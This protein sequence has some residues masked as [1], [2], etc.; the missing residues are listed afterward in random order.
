M[1]F[2]TRLGDS[3]DNVPFLQV[4]TTP[5]SVVERIKRVLPG[6]I[7]ITWSVR[8]SN[9]DL[10]NDSD[11]EWQIQE[12]RIIGSIQRK[13]SLRRLRKRFGPFEKSDVHTMSAEEA[14]A[15]DLVATGVPL[16]DLENANY[17][18]FWQITGRKW[19]RNLT[20]FIER[21]LIRVQYDV[22]DD[23]LL[24]IA[25]IAQ[26]S[27]NQIASLV[28]SLLE[29]TPTS[30]AMIGDDGKSGIVL[31]RLPESSAYQITSTLPNEGYKH[32]MQIR[33]LRPTSYQSYSYNLYQRLL[34]EDGTWDD[35]VSAFL[36]QARS[37]RRELSES[38]A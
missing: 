21:E 31:S 5:L 3:R 29:N 30:L 24:S 8:N 34:R 27:P 33:C 1:R 32:D 16:D 28:E 36:S 35:D 25:T 23:R 38:N 17:T 13:G 22:R 19:K 10:F 18:D 6:A 7:Q 2:I 4:L 20:S 11:K 26:G 14:K 9:L 15:I 12:D 37:K